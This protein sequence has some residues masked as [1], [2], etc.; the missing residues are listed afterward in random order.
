MSANAAMIPGKRRARFIHV[1]LVAIA[2]P[3][4][5]I[6]LH[7]ST[8]TGQRKWISWTSSRQ[9][10][11]PRTRSFRFPWDSPEPDQETWTPPWAPPKKSGPLSLANLQ[12]FL[13]ASEPDEELRQRARDL[14]DELKGNDAE[15]DELAYCVIMQ[16]ASKLE[17]DEVVR[18]WFHQAEAAGRQLDNTTFT[19]ILYQTVKRGAGFEAVDFWMERAEKAR[20]IVDFGMI[21]EPSLQTRDAMMT[22]HITRWEMNAQSWPHVQQWNEAKLKEKEARQQANRKWKKSSFLSKMREDIALEF[23]TK[24]GLDID[25]KVA[26]QVKDGLTRDSPFDR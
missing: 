10:L 3:A 1:L 12:D 23:G 25:D 16:A 17:D 24:S 22:S 19:T 26:E 21:K 9:L 18:S 7:A 2:L 20:A 6:T 4:F 11:N 5:R 15:H 14:L 8:F 13:S